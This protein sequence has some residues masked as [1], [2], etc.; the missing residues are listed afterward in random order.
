[1]QHLLQLYK[2]EILLETRKP[3]TPCDANKISIEC[4]DSLV[5]ISMVI[6]LT[7]QQ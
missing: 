5:S 7:C 4:V 1:M 2:I 6:G 3:Y